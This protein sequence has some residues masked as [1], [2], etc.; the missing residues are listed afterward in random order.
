VLDRRENQ[1]K[2]ELE[3]EWIGYRKAEEEEVVHPSLLKDSRVSLRVVDSAAKT[4][5][6]GSRRFGEAK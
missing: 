3:G 2:H 4:R 6:S 5:T 1:L